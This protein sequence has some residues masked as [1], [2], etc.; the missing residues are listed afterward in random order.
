[1][2]TGNDYVVYILWGTP[3]R[4]VVVYA[5]DVVDVEETTFR[6]AEETRVILDCIAFGGGVDY[7]EHFFE[8]F[9]EELLGLLK[10][11]VFRYVMKGI[12]EEVY[13]NGGRVQ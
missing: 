9:L 13:G 7:G 6:A 8:M 10:L 5:V 12:W 4:Q 2:S 3:L 1:M 11:V